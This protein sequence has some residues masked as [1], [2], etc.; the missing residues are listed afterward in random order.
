MAAKLQD[1][2]RSTETEMLGLMDSVQRLFY[3]GVDDSNILGAF[4]KLSPA[5]DVTRLKGEAAIKNV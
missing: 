4:S 1:A 5:L 2:T 3:A